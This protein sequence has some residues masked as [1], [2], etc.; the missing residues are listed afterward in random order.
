[1][2][3]VSAALNTICVFGL[4]EAG[5][6]FAADLAAAGVEVHGFDPKDVVTPPAV[7]RH[8]NPQDAVA[9]VDMIIALTAAADAETALQQA[10]ENIPGTALYADFSTAAADLKHSL[11]ERCAQRAIDFCD[12]ALMSVV[13]GK[14]IKTPALA[15]GSG[16]E[17]FSAVFAAL[18]M[19]V[20]AISNQ[21][22]DAAT[23][24]LLRSVMM[25]GLAAVVIEAMQAAEQAG[26]AEWLWENMANE[27][28]NADELLLTRLVKGTRTHA[29]R[30]L[31]EMQASVELLESLQVDPLMTRA[32]AANL[33]MV[34]E[35]WPNNPGSAGKLPGWWSI[36]GK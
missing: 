11:S 17:A 3:Q 29:L 4:G 27:I 15:S 28:S 10:F 7:I 2:N 33:Q 22:G 1:V 25:K 8:D 9:N 34:L 24:K 32:T 36:P 30:R 35:N 14:G 16:A 5:S 13:P 26:C 21:A 18:G 31:H 6:L 23:R 20:Q 19:P 12:V